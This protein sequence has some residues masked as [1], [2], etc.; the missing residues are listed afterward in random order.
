MS[1]LCMLRQET[2]T[3]HDRSINLLGVNVRLRHIV[4][5]VNVLSS[6]RSRDDR[7]GAPAAAASG[8]QVPE[9]M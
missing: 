6:A 5:Y 4:R 9:A 3:L 8:V 2:S 1:W 7:I